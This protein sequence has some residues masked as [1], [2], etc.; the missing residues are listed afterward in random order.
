MRCSAPRSPLPSPRPCLPPPPLCLA[1]RCL[2]GA[3]LWGPA[4]ER[5]GQGGTRPRCADMTHVAEPR[6]ANSAGEGEARLCKR[7]WLGGG[8]PPL[9]ERPEPSVP[10]EADLDALRNRPRYPQPPPPSFQASAG[11]GWTEGCF[12]LPPLRA[13][14][15]SISLSRLVP[16]A[17]G[18]STWPG[19]GG[20]EGEK[21]GLVGGLAGQAN[22][23]L[24][25]LR[26]NTLAPLQARGRL[27]HRGKRAPSPHP[28]PGRFGVRG[29]LWARLA[30][31]LAPRC[32]AGAA[33][34]ASAWRGGGGGGRGE[35][36]ALR[37]LSLLGRATP[38]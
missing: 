34:S 3:E 12:Q 2:Y 11:D 1:C 18:E 7:G 19:G 28:P 25:A 15:C 16:R 27:S 14:H 23:R 20:E 38:V 32:S 5:G 22:W 4:G 13:L 9:S 10:A 6:T 36:E 29:M 33:D 31:C 35:W 26:G 21:A 8:V 37:L 24:G 17:R 30:G